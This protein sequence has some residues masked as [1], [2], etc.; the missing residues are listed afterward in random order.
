MVV[1]NR[2]F[3]PNSYHMDTGNSLLYIHRDSLAINFLVWRMERIYYS[4][5]QQKT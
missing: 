4:I 3:F 5:A 1:R 2:S